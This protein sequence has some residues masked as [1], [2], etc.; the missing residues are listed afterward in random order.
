WSLGVEEQFYL[1]FPALLYLLHTKSR[2]LLLIF[3]AGLA[4]ASL[5]AS[6]WAV[7]SAPSAAFYLLPF[8]T[9]ELMFGAILALAEFPVPQSMVIR[10]LLAAIGLALI[11][12]AVFL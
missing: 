1:L 10:D 12:R 3:V 2:R 6:I 4:A 8:R 9:W 11:G 7:H 5:V